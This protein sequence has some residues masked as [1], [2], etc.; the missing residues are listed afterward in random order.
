[1]SVRKSLT[2]AD[3]PMTHMEYWLWNRYRLVQQR[4]AQ[5]RKG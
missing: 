4:L 1:M 3:A 5:Q 2:G